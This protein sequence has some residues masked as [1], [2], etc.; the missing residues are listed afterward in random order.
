MA[1]WLLYGANGYTGQLIAEEAR[2]RGL[3]PVLAG[4]REAPVR[5]LA[6]RLD[7]PWRVFR[8]DDP[9]ALDAALREFRTVVLAAGPFS[10]TS[11]PVVDAC[12]R[13]GASYLDI[14]GEID[15]F[16]RTLSL[17]DQAR[18][19]A[20]VLLPGVGFDV[21]PSDCLAASLAAALPHATTL[22]LAIASLGS[23]S[24]H[25]TLLTML[26]GMPRGSARREAGIIRREPLL[27]RSRSVRFHD[28]VRD[29]VAIPWGD[30]STAYHSTGIPNIVVW[31]AVAASARRW[32]PLVRHVLPVLGWPGVQRVVQRLA[33][34]GAA[35]PDAHTRARARSELWG[36]VTN[37][38]GQRVEG[39]L[40][41]PNG[42]VL[43]A[44]TAVECAERV[45]AG[46]L[47]PGAYTPATA[48]GPAFITEFPEC[49]LR[50]PPS[51]N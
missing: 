49:E 50:L 42:Y 23:R 18:Q 39:T 40:S 51:I 1:E 17:G 29:T 5:A 25:G 43:T 16:E 45:A 24:S 47:A 44:R 38:A 3:R 34:R 46:A 22:D 14:T 10:A 4:R 48:F 27:T 30:V 26:E 21:V 15:V 8:L 13:T 9:L 32:A 35:G 41:T 28:G 7:C 11:A 37:A 36:Q 2:R 6:E 33:S 31:M 19:R 20:S 12:L